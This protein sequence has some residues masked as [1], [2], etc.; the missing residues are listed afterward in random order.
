MDF[1]EIKYRL[2][3]GLSVCVE[4]DL[5]KCDFKLQ[6]PTELRLM[7]KIYENITNL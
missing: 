7:L 6:R 5:F 1:S 4:Y 3:G 2:T